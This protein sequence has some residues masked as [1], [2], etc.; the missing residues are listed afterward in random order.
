MLMFIVCYSTS[1]K[2]KRARGGLHQFRTGLV[3]YSHESY[4][5]CDI[6]WQSPGVFF[7]ARLR[8]RLWAGGVEVEGM[9]VGFV[10][11][12]NDGVELEVSMLG[13]GDC[14]LI[15]EF[16]GEELYFG[17]G[18][19]SD[20]TVPVFP[21]LSVCSKSADEHEDCS[22]ICFFDLELGNFNSGSY[23]FRV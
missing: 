17:W 23:Y 22:C 11:L 12:D 18:G 5:S 4:V 10:F 9:F 15:P 6:I 7:G 1:Q 2:K 19:E 13:E 14:F 8:G 3:T 20:T 16:A 21:F